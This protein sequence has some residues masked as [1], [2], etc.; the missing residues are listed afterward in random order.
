M[1]GEDGRRAGTLL[2]QL[3]Q[4]ATVKATVG[5]KLIVESAHDGAP[6]KIGSIIEL[7]HEDGSPPYVVRWE[8][9]EHESLVFP[10][11]DAHVMPS[12]PG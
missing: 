9:D 1:E 4:E 11:P 10:G 5:D 2:I 7:R 6:R 3:I 8:G 12:V